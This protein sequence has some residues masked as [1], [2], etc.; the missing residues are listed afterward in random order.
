[1]TSKRRVRPPAGRAR[2]VAGQLKKID[3]RGRRKRLRRV[4]FHDLAPSLRRVF[5]LETFRPGQEA[6]IRSVLGGRD[7]LAIMPTGA[8]K[9]LCYQLP[10]LHLRGMTVVVS[11]LIS[12]M[13]DQADKL[14][15]LGV[16]ASQINSAL[17]SR[18]E[19]HAL[20]GIA[21]DRPDFIL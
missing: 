6:V 14:G 1:M 15:E 18:E 20:D 10:A 7:T 11:P 4:D 17:S 9:S 16:G 5:N 13:K 19:A 8:G 3:T 12:L 2:R 21:E